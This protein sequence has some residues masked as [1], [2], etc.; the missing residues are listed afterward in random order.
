VHGRR[1]FSE[2][3]GRPASQ[4]VS[5]ASWTAKF[6]WHVDLSYL[7]KYIIDELTSD[8][9]ATWKKMTREIGWH[10]LKC[11]LLPKK[12]TKQI[13]CTIQ[14]HTT[15]H[16][17][18]KCPVSSVKICSIADNNNPQQMNTTSRQTGVAL[19]L[20]LLLFSICE[21]LIRV[22]YTGFIANWKDRIQGHFKDFSRT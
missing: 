1:Q 9:T 6:Q 2:S 10:K 22:G 17:L 15:F 14:N 12:N 11:A 19:Y 13:H 21:Q 3:F 4:A 7:A 18:T 16:L 5:V 8:M 20:V